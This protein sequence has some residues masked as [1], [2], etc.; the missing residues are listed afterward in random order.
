MYSSN[1][2]RTPT[3]SDIKDSLGA[4]GQSGESCLRP[5]HLVLSNQTEPL[6]HGRRSLDVHSSPLDVIE[7]HFE[8]GPPEYKR[9]FKEIFDTLRRSVVYEN[10]DNLSATSKDTFDSVSPRVDSALGHP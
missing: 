6:G 10:M 9:L 5:R 4:C 2:Q 1:L 3:P 8:N 7:R